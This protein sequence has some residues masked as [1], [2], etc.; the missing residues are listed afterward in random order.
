VEG[1][2]D[3]ARHLDRDAGDARIP[4]R[5]VDAGH[6]GEVGAAAPAVRRARREIVLGH[7]QASPE[8][9]EEL[10]GG[11]PVA[12]FDARDV[13]RGA[14]RKRKLALAESGPFARFLQ[15]H[16]HGGGTVDMG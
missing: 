9:A 1:G 7:A 3:V 2:V 10:E 16:T 6:A 5:Q 15:A 14:A 13:G 11:D 4:A 12:R 8:L